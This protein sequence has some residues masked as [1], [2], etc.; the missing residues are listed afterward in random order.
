MRRGMIAVLGLAIVLA[1]PS[2]V[3][4]AGGGIGI[5]GIGGQVSFVKPEDI[6]GTFGLGM[7]AD[8]GE[9]GGGVGLFP[10]VTFWRKSWEE[11]LFGEKWDTTFTEI[12]TN[13]DA[14]YYFLG[15]DTG[16]MRPFVGGGLA[17]IYSSVSCDDFDDSDMDVGI[18][19]L[20]GADF[21]ISDS[22]IG[23]F[24]A[25]YKIDGADVLKLTGGVTFLMGG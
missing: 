3:L 6:D 19:I 9:I 11:S 16:T 23:F 18:N 15:Y 13:A 20:G 1:V 14:R 12:A 24:E 21:D 4:G 10:S 5:Q 8:L 7:H 17:L 25:R 22:M 2:L